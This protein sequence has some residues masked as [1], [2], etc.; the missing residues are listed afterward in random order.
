MVRAWLSRNLPMKEHSHNQMYAQVYMQWE[1]T[2]VNRHFIFKQAPWFNNGNNTRFDFYKFNFP[3]TESELWNIFSCGISNKSAFKICWNNFLISHS[4][5]THTCPIRILSRDIH[6]RTRCFDML[7]EHAIPAFTVWHGILSPIKTLL[8]SF[9]Y[10][11]MKIGRN[12]SDRMDTY[13]SEIKNKK[14]QQKSALFLSEITLEQATFK[15][16]RFPLSYNTNF[17]LIIMKLFR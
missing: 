13:F 10:P 5:M 14:P 3:L 12:S 7:F 4:K 1:M 17:W 9:Q 2:K 16:W 15:I 8:F 11:S 6:N